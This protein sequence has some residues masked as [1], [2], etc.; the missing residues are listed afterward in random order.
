M[1]RD[2]NVAEKARLPVVAS[3]RLHDRFGGCVTGAVLDGAHH[4]DVLRTAWKEDRR[5]I[6]LGSGRFDR[7]REVAGGKFATELGR[8]PRHPRFGPGTRSST[9]DYSRAIV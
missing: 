1:G 8:G 9:P 3:G 4:V 2:A 5:E 7:N 6:R